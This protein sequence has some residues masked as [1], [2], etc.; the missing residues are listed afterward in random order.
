[1]NYNWSS[2]V[3]VTCKNANLFN[4]SGVVFCEGCA[5]TVIKPFQGSSL[6]L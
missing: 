3:F 1:M 2:A 6:I 5:Y 4:P